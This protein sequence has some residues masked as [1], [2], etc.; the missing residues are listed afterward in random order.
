MMVPARHPNTQL[1][2][3]LRLSYLNV[4]DQRCWTLRVG[5]YISQARTLDRYEAK[6]AFLGFE[7]VAVPYDQQC[8]WTGRGMFGTTFN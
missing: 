1:G 8:V 3:R 6:E 7:K 4:I 2:R 5:C